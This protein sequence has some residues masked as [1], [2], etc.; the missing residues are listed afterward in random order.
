MFSFTLAQSEKSTEEGEYKL[1]VDATLEGLHQSLFGKCVKGKKLGKG[2]IRG[3]L[4]D[5]P[6]NDENLEYSRLLI[7]DADAGLDGKPTPSAQ[8]CHEALVSLGYSHVIYTTFSH[9][10]EYH[11]YRA[12]V[13]LDSDIQQHELHANVSR[14]IEELKAQGCALKYAHEMDTWSQIWFLPRSE[15]PETFINYGWFDG[16][17]FDAIHLE[18]SEEQKRERKTR[19]TQSEPSGK[20]ET[21]DQMFE[22]IRTG[23]E[24]HN[25]LR[26]LSFQLAKDGVSRAIILATLNNAMESSKEAGSERWVTRM[27]ELERLVDGGISRATEEEQESF[28]IPE[29]VV[30][31]VKYT[32][33]PI[34][35]GRLGRF[36]MQIMKGMANPQIEF[37]FAM[38]L[39]SVAAICG[40]KFNAKT[41]QYSGLNLNMTVVADTGFGKGQ[42]SKFYRLLF[43]GGLDGKIVSLAGGDGSSSFVGDNNYTAP[44]P[45]H[46]DLM[47]G[48]SKVVCMQ[49]AGIMLGAK[50]GNADE[51]SAYVMENYVNSAHNNWSSSR[52]Y[53]NDENSL[54]A[55]RAPAMT[56]VLES[57]EESLAASLKDMNALESGYIPRQTM[58]KVNGK[59]RMNRSR[60][61]DATYAFD[62]DIVEHLQVLID[63]C[64][65]IQALSDFTPNIVNWSDERYIE[66]CDLTDHYA[67]AYDHDKVSKIIA[68]RM[69]HK[70]IKFAALAAAFNYWTKGDIDVDDE[71]WEWAKSMG[72]WEMDNIDHNLSYMKEENV[73]DYAIYH[74]REVLVATLNHKDTMVKQRAQKVVRMALIKDRLTSKFKQLAQEK[75]MPHEVFMMTTLRQLEKMGEVKVL[76]SH[77]A[78]KK[79]N[80][81]CVQLL[82]AFVDK[83]GE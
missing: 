22:N 74:L 50:S 78:F 71:S 52:A 72:Q 23:T 64:A 30:K 48:R 29:A 18:E 45:L 68:S 63:E 42:I 11:K 36:I 62:A 61:E 67:E 66:L 24:F 13:E 54:K 4:K 1:F 44:K 81:P 69:A 33:P 40:A 6:R 17:T 28:D 65:K 15:H 21:L 19:Q 38:G 53:S 3:A 27:K 10:E 70:V 60:T 79:R 55:F 51:F 41:N 26:N 46:R 39:G 47:M 82:S 83:A 56:L 37:A 25:S 31:E 16:T 34:P 2:I 73:Y 7:L 5:A 20:T 80:T 59:P 57:T 9:T 35:P 75:H 8:A 12:F 43:M 76:D 14:L 58:F 77:P 32:P 49:E